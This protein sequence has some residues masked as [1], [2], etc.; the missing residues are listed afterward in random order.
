[1]TLYHPDHQYRG[2]GFTHHEDDNCVKGNIGSDIER[3][4]VDIETKIK[5]LKRPDVPKAVY[6]IEAELSDLVELIENEM[7]ASFRQGY[8]DG[9]LDE[10][11]RT[12][13]AC[14]AVANHISDAR[15][16]VDDH[17]HC[18]ECGYHG[19]HAAGCD[20]DIFE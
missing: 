20:L 3:Q 1:M 15:K 16:K 10:I 12:K 6:M 17:G 5:A 7:I 9:G 13:Q 11:L 19:R 18:I 8:I 2:D 4:P 14:K